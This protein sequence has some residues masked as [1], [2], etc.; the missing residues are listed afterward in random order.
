MA[1][2]AGMGWAEFWESSPYA[3]RLILEAWAEAERAVYERVTTGAFHG[4]Y[5]ARFDKL[6]PRD[7]EKALGRKPTA[8]KQQTDD[9]VGRS[10]F[11]WLKAAEPADDSARH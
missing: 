2:R 9:E 5:F 10:I 8:S 11:A 1:L 3:T 7:L 4:A 6:G